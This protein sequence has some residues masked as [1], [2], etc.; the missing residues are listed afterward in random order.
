MSLKDVTQPFPSQGMIKRAM[1]MVVL[2]LE[3]G[4][5]VH[6]PGHD[7]HKVTKE[8]KFYTCDCLGYQMRGMCSHVAAVK[9]MQAPKAQE[10]LFGDE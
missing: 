10:D 8:I 7:V 9:I 3:E 6:E 5:R 4:W 2:P 1:F